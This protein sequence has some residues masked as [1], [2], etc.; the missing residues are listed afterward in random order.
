MWISCPP[1]NDPGPVPP[2]P[3]CVNIDV[4]AQNKYCGFFNL[5]TG[6]PFDQCLNVNIILILFFFYIS[7]F[8]K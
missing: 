6:S 1:I 2:N 4:Y 3:I 5:N 8:K 7:N